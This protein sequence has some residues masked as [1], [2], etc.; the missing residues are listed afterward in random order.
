[1]G[2]SGAGHFGKMVRNGI[3]HALM[4]AYAQGFKLMQARQDFRLD[5]AAVGG[6][7]R[8]GSV[9]RSWLLDLAVKA[10]NETVCASGNT[11]Q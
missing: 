3:E 7:W 6:T 10:M 2:P 5:L 4:Q 11:S 1:V 9:V 8:H